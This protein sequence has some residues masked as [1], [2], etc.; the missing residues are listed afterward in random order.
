MACLRRTAHANHTPVRPQA[1]HR[2]CKFSSSTNRRRSPMSSAGS[3]K[4]IYIEEMRDLW[5][6][7][8]QMQG[9]M[10]SLSEKASDSK[11]KEMLAKSVG[12]IGQHT[13]T[14]KSILEARGGN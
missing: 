12:G 7:N 3:L 5:S 6:A 11:L 4:D 9:V 1:F 2:L 13:A 14:L 8:D 10:Q